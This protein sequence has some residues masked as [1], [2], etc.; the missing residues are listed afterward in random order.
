MQ[1]RFSANS[2]LNTVR[3]GGLNRSKQI[4]ATSVIVACSFLLLAGCNTGPVPAPTAYTR[5]A[6]NDKQYICEYPDGWEITAAGGNTTK[7]RSA[8]EKGSA[9]I[10]ITCDIAGSLMAGATTRRD[11][12]DEP[13]VAM[14]HERSKDRLLEDMPGAEEQPPQA[15][16]TAGMM[17]GRVSE[18]TAPGSMGK[19]IRGYRATVLTRDRR[20]VIICQ[21][22]ES[23]WDNLKPAFMKVI[24]SIGPGSGK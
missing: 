4:P 13:P 10:A 8:C 6:S 21:C 12:D 2:N 11:P 17:E 14:A 22:A 24:Q 3:I 7:S 5:F 1:T 20:L 15:V 19:K 23:D 18:F 16:Q 9:K